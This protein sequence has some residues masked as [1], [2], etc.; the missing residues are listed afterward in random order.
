MNP[1][2]DKPQPQPDPRI[3]AYLATLPKHPP[4]ETQ[5]AALVAI[6][7][8]LERMKIRAQAKDNPPQPAD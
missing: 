3:V 4:L 6:G 2:A 8:G 1:L 5:V 7:E